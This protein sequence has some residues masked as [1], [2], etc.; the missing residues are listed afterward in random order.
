[1]SRRASRRVGVEPIHPSTK[2]AID[3]AAAQLANARRMLF[4][5]KNFKN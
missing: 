1:L 5:A 4:A 2:L 3:Q